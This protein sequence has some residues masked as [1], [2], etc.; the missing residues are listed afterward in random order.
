MEKLVKYQKALALQ[1]E[2]PAVAMYLQAYKYIHLEKECLRC[3]MQLK[4]LK[5]ELNE[6][7]YHD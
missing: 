6:L 4:K 5:Q 1:K 2:T 3:A 7:Q